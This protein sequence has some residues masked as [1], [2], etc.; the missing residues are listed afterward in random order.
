MLRTVFFP[1]CRMTLMETIAGAEALNDGLLTLAKKYS[2]LSVQP[3][4]AWFGYDP[5]HVRRSRALAAWQSLFAPWSA[6]AESLVA[7]GARWHWLRLRTARAA[8]RRWLGWELRARQPALVYA[9][10][11]AVSLY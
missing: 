2:C 10:G 8:Q 4:D 7:S 6:A 11:S 3:V 1:R 5:I 9:D